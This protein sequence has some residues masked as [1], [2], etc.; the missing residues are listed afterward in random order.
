MIAN[1]DNRHKKREREKTGSGHPQPHCALGSLFP[2][3]QILRSGSK[4]SVLSRDQ[5]PVTVCPPVTRNIF[6]KY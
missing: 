4:I 1:P 6:N 3:L 2:D 5:P